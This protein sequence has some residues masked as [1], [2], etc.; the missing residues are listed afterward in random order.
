LFGFLPPL[1][2]SGH[3]FTKRITFYINDLIE[4][5]KVPVA[6]IAGTGCQPPAKSAE[7]LPDICTMD[8]WTKSKEA[9]VAPAQSPL[10]IPVRRRI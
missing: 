10:I 1:Q 9:D 8:C 2:S 5:A 7:V 4:K 6:I 3:A